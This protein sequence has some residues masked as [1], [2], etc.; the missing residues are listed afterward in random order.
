MRAGKTGA[1]V[2]SK[3]W[4]TESVK[5]V[6]VVGGGEGSEGGREEMTISRKYDSSGTHALCAQR[7]ALLLGTRTCSPP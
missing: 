1:G 5:A 3:Y 6:I 4:A 2:A 7:D